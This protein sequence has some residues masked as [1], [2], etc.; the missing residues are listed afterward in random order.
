MNK[1]FISEKSDAWRKVLTSALDED[2]QLTIWPNGKDFF[3]LLKSEYFHVIIL[4][5][6]DSKE[7]NF[8]LLRWIRSSIPATPVIMTSAVD[9]TE[10]VVKAVKQGAFDFLVKPFS[11]AKLRHSVQ[12]ALEN[13]SLRN[14]IEYLRHTQDIVY[15]F[16]RIIAF[17]PV[18]KSVI[19]TLKKF[20]QTDS[21][22]LLTGETGT[23]KSFLS[24]TI[25]FNSRRRD[26]PFIHINCANI[27]ETLLESE[28]F[29]HEKGAFTGANKLRLGRF[30]QAHGGTIFLD[31]IGE[32]SPAIQAKLLRVLE[33]RSFERVGGNRTIHSDVRVIVATNRN[34]KDQI[35]AGKFRHDLYYRINV[36]SLRLPPLRERTQCLEPLS[37]WI[38]EKVCAALRKRIPGFTMECMEWIKAYT[39]PGNIR[40][41][42]N[43]IE[44]AVILEEGD[45]IGRESIM[46]ADQE[47]SLVTPISAHDSVSKEHT[48]IS[49]PG[50]ITPHTLEAREREAIISALDKSLWIQKDAALFLG[51]SPRAL[52]YK[53]K[54]FG[55]THERWRKHRP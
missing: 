14:E 53:I 43:M 7:E 38:L 42:S 40:Q 39:W 52:N 10:L 23:G 8:D 41:L 37:Y 5:M 30:E 44:R 50:G 49:I 3:E 17:S 54:K 12:Q 15:D 33:D 13:R 26:K 2:F 36:L 24:G 25:H 34:L 4:D 29:G 32:I 19:N 27:P 46:V 35:E 22:I 28:L 9:K 16:G 21:T 45:V 31:E 47:G 11:A 6:E 20:A 55:I 48:L 1:V 18:M 51:I